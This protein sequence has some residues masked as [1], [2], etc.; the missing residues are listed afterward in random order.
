MAV[1]PAGP[2]GIYLLGG[3][4]PFRQGDQCLYG[5]TKISNSPI[6]W[7][8]NENILYGECYALLRVVV[9]SKAKFSPSCPIYTHAFPL[10]IYYSIYRPI[11]VSHFYLVHHVLLVI[12]FLLSV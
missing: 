12:L 10:Q 9:D 5:T 1:I 6:K 8:I 3:V 4:Q 11:K 7:N 2:C